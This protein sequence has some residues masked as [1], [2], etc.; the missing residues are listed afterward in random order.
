[1]HKMENRSAHDIHQRP[2]SS[3]FTA[4]EMVSHTYQE[5]T[6]KKNNNNHI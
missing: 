4:S 5:A 2:V 6:K 3:Q 1:M